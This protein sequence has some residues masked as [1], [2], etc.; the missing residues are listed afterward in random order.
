VTPLLTVERLSIALPGGAPLLDAADVTLRAGEVTVLLGPSGAGK[1]TIVRALLSPDEL[2]AQGYRLDWSSRAL[3]GEAAIVPQRGALLDHLDVAGNIEVAQAAGGRARDAGVWLRAV[4]LDPSLAERGRPVAALSGGQAQRVAVAR[5]LAAGRTIVVL[6]EPSVG[7]DPA[8]VRTLAKL[9]VAQARE[10]GAALLVITHDLALAAG[11][12]DTLLFLDP[13]ARTLGPL[14]PDWGG[15]AEL[16]DDDARRARVDELEI[17]LERRLLATPLAKPGKAKRRGPGS[18]SALR[19]LGAAVVRA[20]DP[21]LFRESAVV[22]LRALRQSVLLPL[23]FYVVV[24]VLLGVT[25]PYVIANISV[26]LKAATVLRMIGGTYVVSLVPPLSAILFVA[27]SGNAVNAWLGGMRL[28]GQVTALEGLGVPPSRYL[29]SPAWLALAASYVLS[30][31]AFFA[32][33]T[34]GG[35]LLFRFYDVPEALRVIT[36]DV[37]DAPP[38]RRKYL[39]RAIWLVATYAVSIA[40]IVVS[41]GGAPKERSD[42]VTAAMTSAVMRTTLLVVVLELASIAI[43]FARGGR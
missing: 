27:T 35:F 6:D 24:G 42:D 7:L 33:M 10:Q 20:F 41:R 12:G 36:S 38:A 25:V 30:A 15:P 5:T 17:A 13:S 21:R 19:V 8:A 22:M 9:L 32:A 31:V 43:L 14:L 16:A 28:G 3:A 2:R 39:V 1:T 40:T 26:D 29:W 37:L 11:A 34:L 23:P 18:L 4:D